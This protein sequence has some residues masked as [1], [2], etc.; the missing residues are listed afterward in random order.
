MTITPSEIIYGAIWLTVVIAFA[1]LIVKF[2][3]KED[4][5]NRYDLHR[6]TTI[7]AES[8][9][10]SFS[11]EVWDNYVDIGPYDDNAVR[12]WWWLVSPIWFSWD[13]GTAAMEVFPTA[14]VRK[15]NNV[16]EFVK[17][18]SSCSYRFVTAV[19]YVNYYDYTQHVYVFLGCWE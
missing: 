5:E 3:P 12:A 16:E 10:R 19:E 4:V 14:Y 13:D 2:L 6:T 11:E 18:Q 8:S 15:F 1:V 7:A 9:M 17:W